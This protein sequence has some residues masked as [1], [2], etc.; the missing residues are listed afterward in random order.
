MPQKTKNP[1]TQSFNAELNAD[2]SIGPR[3]K[4]IGIGGGGGLIVSEIAQRVE[5]VSFVAVDTD[6]RALRELP[7]KIK[8]FQFAVDAERGIKNLFE[9]TD[10]CILV[11]C[12][13]GGA[14]S[15][16]LPMLADASRRRRVITFGVFVLPFEFEGE[17]KMELARAALA[18]AKSNI[19]ASV[20]VSNQ[21]LFN[22]INKSTPFK[23]AFSI[24]NK[25]I[26]EDLKGLVEMIDSSGLISINFADLKM[27][28]TGRGKLAFLNSVEAEVSQSIQGTARKVVFNRLSPY[29]AYKAKKILF[30]ITGGENLNINEINQVGS[31]ISNLVNPQAKIIFGIT[32]N[33]KYKD[34]IKITLLAAGCR[35]QEQEESHEKS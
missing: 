25:R 31:I 22:I 5:K 24:V 30:N 23:E 4:I 27:A 29:L 16:I 6:S 1:P 28:L 34:K 14:G 21:K 7:R 9:E 35:W 8:R 18:M 33:K 2:I 32:Q 12:L 19:S 13:G 3:V 17:K 26:T 20:V 10:F 11:A 15:D